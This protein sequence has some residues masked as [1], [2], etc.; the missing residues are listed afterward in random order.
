M[1]SKKSI[2]LP[3]LTRGWP[4]RIKNQFYENIFFLHSICHLRNPPYTEL[5]Q[6]FK[7]LKFYKGIS[8]RTSEFS[9]KKKTNLKTVSK[10]ISF[11]FANQSVVLDLPIK[12][13]IGRISSVKDWPK[14]GVLTNRPPSCRK[15]T[16]Y[17]I[18]NWRALYRY[19][20]SQ[21]TEY[22]GNLTCQIIEFL[23]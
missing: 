20:N 11:L 5:E 21:K 22:F 1:L 4:V 17:D 14:I 18:C 12:I 10:N 8:F 16:N 13:Q 6:L 9:W 7:K 23:L 15:V 3:F 2:W 19:E